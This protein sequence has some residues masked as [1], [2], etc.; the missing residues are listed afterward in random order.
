MRSHYG[1]R[2]NKK[3]RDRNKPWAGRKCLIH[4]T[5]GQTISGLYQELQLVPSQLMEVPEKCKRNMVDDSE[6]KK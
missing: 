1:K 2:T 4:K 6:L 3:N 5:S